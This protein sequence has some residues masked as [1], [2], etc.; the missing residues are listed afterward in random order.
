MPPRA[1]SSATWAATI[2]AIEPSAT[3]VL[4]CSGEARKVMLAEI[5]DV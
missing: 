4:A 5:V 1:S 2:V 3:G